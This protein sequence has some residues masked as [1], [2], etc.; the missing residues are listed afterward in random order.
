MAGGGLCGGG[1]DGARCVPAV[2]RLTHTHPVQ[3]AGDDVEHH[4]SQRQP[5]V[6]V[7]ACTWDRNSGDDSAATDV[8]GGT[9]LA[10]SSTW[11][12]SGRARRGVGHRRDAVA[13]AGLSGV[14]WER[15]AG[16]VVLVLLAL[17]VLLV[18][19]SPVPHARDGVGAPTAVVVGGLGVALL[20]RA[21]PHD[22]PSPAGPGPARGARRRPRRPART[23][24]VA[25]RGGHLRGRRRRARDHIPGRGVD[26]RLRPR[27]RPSWCRSRRWCC[28]R[29]SFR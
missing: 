24:G 25:G 12:A 9:A 10:D 16:P 8:V 23:A 20:L 17:V 7:E 22:G 14:G 3:P 5:T 27:R 21:L 15:A 6:G 19:D 29:W 2:D 4:H 26:H 13:S 1:P 28:W 18:L 11:W